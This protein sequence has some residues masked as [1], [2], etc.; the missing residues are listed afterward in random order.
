MLLS[1]ACSFLH[2]INSSDGTFTEEA[3]ASVYKAKY[4][5]LHV[6]ETNQAAIG[7][8]RDTLGFEVANTEKGYCEPALTNAWH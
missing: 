5:S 7:L 8:Y 2:V 3:M 6:R 4:V 1:R